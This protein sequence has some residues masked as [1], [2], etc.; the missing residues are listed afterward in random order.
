VKY[1][2]T[3]GKRTVEV[4]VR[5]DGV[6]VD[7]EAIRAHLTTVPRTPLRHLALDS[8]ASTLAL[9]RSE[10]GWTVHLAGVPWP[11]TVE[12]ERTRQLRALT[13]QGTR[14]A[15][16][17][18]VR[19]PM[20]GLVL[21]V[22]VEVGQEVAAGAGLAVLEAMKM[23]NEIKAQAAGTVAAVHVVPG[24]AVEKGAALVELRAEG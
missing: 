2:V 23:E 4:E 14:G 22:E 18:M 7:G 3:I 19:A 11:V 20:P 13:G 16:G 8:R 6:Q 5:G 24:Q 1:T 10:A 9:L 15:A 21:R 12:D 17:G